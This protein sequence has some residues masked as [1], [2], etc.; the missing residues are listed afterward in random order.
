MSPGP[1]EG[2]KTSKAVVAAKS[3][4]RLSGTVARQVGKV[5]PLLNRKVVTFFP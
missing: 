2:V 5:T 3:G 4:E 1:A